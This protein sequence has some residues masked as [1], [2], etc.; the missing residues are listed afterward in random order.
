MVPHIT[1]EIIEKQKSLQPGTCLGFGLGFKI[2]LI[3][4]LEMPNPSPLSGNCDV[5]G[6]WCGNGSNNAIQTNVMENII[7]SPTTPNNITIGEVPNFEDKVAEPIIDIIDSLKQS[8][9]TSSDGGAT[10]INVVDSP[11]ASIP[12]PKDNG[13]VDVDT[14][15]VNDS[16]EEKPA[17]LKVVDD[18]PSENKE[19]KVSEVISHLNTD[20]SSDKNNEVVENPA[21]SFI[22]SF[23]STSNAAIPEISDVKIEDNGMTAVQTPGADLT[24]DDTDDDSSDSD[25][26]D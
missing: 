18:E 1:D 7:T 20:D 15:D 23:N 8:E 16:K 9:E 4:K 3:I 2:P 13:S 12:L 22:N 14:T 24:L 26:D 25:F 6:I 5:V 21:L 19:D 10:L 17:L 11:D